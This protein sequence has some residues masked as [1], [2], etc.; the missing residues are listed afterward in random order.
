MPRWRRQTEKSPH[1][2]GRRTGWSPLTRRILTLNVMALAFLGGATLYLDQ[3]RTNLTNARLAAMTTQGEIIA[4]AIGE[5]AISSPFDNYISPRVGR[6]ILRRL[7]IPTGTRGRLFTADGRLIADSRALLA[8]RQVLTRT[9]PPEDPEGGVIQWLNRAYDRLAGRLVEWIIPP[10]RHDLATGFLAPFTDIE[11]GHANDFYEV[12]TALKGK[13]VAARRTAPDGAVILSIA[14][15]VQR[16]HQV[17]GALLLSSGTS[18]IEHSVRVQQLTILGIF[19]LVLGITVMLTLYLAG[20]I[21]RPIQILAEA[22]DQIRQRSGRTVTIPDFSHREDEIGDLSASLGEM[23]RALY[24]R[25]DA[26]ESFAADVAHEI[27][28]PLTSLRSAVEAGQHITDPEKLKQLSDIIEDDIRRLDRLIS[29]ISDASRLDAELSRAEPHPFE[30]ATMLESLTDIYRTGGL[31][32]RNEQRIEL[33]LMLPEGDRLLFTGLEQELG[34]VVRN[35]LDNA[36]SFSPDTGTIT[37]S[38]RRNDGEIIVEIEDQGP[39]IPPGLEASIFRR[40]YSERPSSET[41]G[42]HSGLGLS[43]SLQIVK[44][45]EGTIEAESIVGDGDRVVGARF[46]ITLPT[47]RSQ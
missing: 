36:I 45:H 35:L 9:L 38:A 24:D 4:A 22:A 33:A 21:V 15:P 6:L 37:I 20:S 34:Q 3:L 32:S 46:R 25:I 16:L 1:R 19:L 40:F 2:A 8:G 11:G 30:F 39:G 41:F 17:V 12:I 5:T 44:A 10:A 7:V 18:D 47:A 31:L 28:N 27:K 29:D 42:L 26:I 43:I 13:P 23:T 14:L